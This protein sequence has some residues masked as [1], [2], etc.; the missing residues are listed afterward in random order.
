MK[1][2][3]FVC[4]LE[5]KVA[6]SAH[7]KPLGFYVHR[8]CSDHNVPVAGLTETCNVYRFSA[9]HMYSCQLPTIGNFLTEFAQCIVL[10]GSEPKNMLC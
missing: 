4:R 1:K 7:S 9:M 6:T 10:H 8:V 3:C 5:H 2:G